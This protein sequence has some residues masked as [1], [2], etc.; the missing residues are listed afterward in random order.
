M[1]EERSARD[2]RRTVRLRHATHGAKLLELRASG[3]DA[4][5][6]MGEMPELRVVGI[7]RAYE[8]AAANR[9]HYADFFDANGQLQG[10]GL[11]PA[12]AALA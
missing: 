7:A 9:E 4:Q 11:T 1:G 3:Y 6:L 10:P 2:E 5:R 12:E 8:F